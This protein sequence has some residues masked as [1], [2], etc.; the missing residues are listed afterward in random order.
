M[1]KGTGTLKP[2]RS[3]VYRYLISC[4]SVCA[5]AVWIPS[6]ARAI[7]LTQVKHLFDISHRFNY[8]SDVAVSKEGRIHIV[9]GVNNTVKIFNYDGVY[10][11]SFGRA[12]SNDGELQ[13]PLGIDIDAFGRI[14][15]ADAGNHRVQI[16]NA[17]GEFMAQ[18]PIP[19][20]DRHAGDPTDVVVD[21]GGNRCYVVDNDN[22]R[23]LAFNLTNSKLINAY[24]KPGTANLE[25]KYPF[26]ITL[27]KNRSLYIVDVTNTRVQV[28]NPS[29]LFVGNIGGWGV[30]KGEFFRPKGVAVDKDN[31]VFVSDSYMGVIQ[32]FKPT[33]EFHAVVG[34]PSNHAVKKFKTPVGLF[35]DHNNRLYVVEM[36]ANRVG[37]YSIQGDARSY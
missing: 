23:V 32:V 24:G 36:I 29:G 21:V 11:S 26:M 7:L 31:R 30:E 18:I 28:L 27:D 25:F 9:D 2:N 6:P 1:R 33:G 5:L 16:F 3:K 20:T 13:Q 17:D 15:I 37:V 12:G 34:D 8:P 35:I 14:Y 10:F 22:H 19:A 4:V